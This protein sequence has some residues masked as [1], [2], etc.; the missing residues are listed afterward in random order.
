MSCSNVSLPCEGAVPL[1]NAAVCSLLCKHTGSRSLGEVINAPK[2]K[3]YLMCWFSPPE[4]PIFPIYAQHSRDET[5]GL[6]VQATVTS[7]ELPN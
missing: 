2:Y 7:T 1:K 6:A 3:V 4:V 5:Q